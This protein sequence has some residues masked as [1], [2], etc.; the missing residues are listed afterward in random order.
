M[1]DKTK[2]AFNLEERLID[3]AVLIIETVE[4]LP[5]TILSRISYLKRNSVLNECNGLIAIFNK[6]VITA[7]RNVRC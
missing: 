4:S 2:K 3:F 7:K 6:S 5:E 1:S